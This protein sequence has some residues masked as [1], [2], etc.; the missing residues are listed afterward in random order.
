MRAV[1]CLWGMGF[2]IVG[3]GGWFGGVPGGFGLVEVVKWWA[4]V[5]EAHWFRWRLVLLDFDQG[6][7]VPIGSVERGFELCRR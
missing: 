3:Q 2:E 5:V 7:V 6:L 1:L 4:Q